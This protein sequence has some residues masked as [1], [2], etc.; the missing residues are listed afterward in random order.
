MGAVSQRRRRVASGCAAR[1]I[2]LLGR[3]ELLPKPRES[4][5]LSPLAGQLSAIMPQLSKNPA[6]LLEAL[7][8]RF[9]TAKDRRV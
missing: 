7:S 8:S 9:K 3:H 2:L 1:E 6:K 5:A 4:H